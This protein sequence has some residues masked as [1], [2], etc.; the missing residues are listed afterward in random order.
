MTEEEK[1]KIA[2]ELRS[3]YQQ[4]GASAHYFNKVQE[5]IN[6]GLLHLRNADMRCSEIAYK[7]GIQKEVIFG[8]KEETEK[9]LATYDPNLNSF[10]YDTSK[11][12]Q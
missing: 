7:Y 9:S 12:N 3:I 10:S 6:E 1:K 11:T 2:G 5:L 4:I 8:E